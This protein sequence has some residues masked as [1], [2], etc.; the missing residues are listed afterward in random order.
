MKPT[1]FPTRALALLSLAGLGVFAFLGR[2]SRA[3]SAPAAP[4]AAAPVVEHGVQAPLVVRF[5]EAPTQLA[6]GETS[7]TVHI[8]VRTPL[9]F[10]VSLRASLPRGAVLTDGQLDEALDVTQAGT[11]H[12]TFRFRAADE[13]N[14]KNPFRV[15]VHGEAP[16]RSMGLHADR[17]FPAQSVVAVPPFAGP[18]PPGGRPPGPLKR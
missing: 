12:R 18:R 13:M 8:D 5:D 17:T 9:T 2:A 14:E 6:S 7:L 4:R 3:D 15:V 1:S 11:L 16:D 10:P